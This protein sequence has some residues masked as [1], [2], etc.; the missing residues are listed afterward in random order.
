MRCSSLMD[1]STDWQSSPIGPTFERTRA[2]HH[3]GRRLPGVLFQQAAANARTDWRDLFEG[4]AE[5]LPETNRYAFQRR[6]L[7]QQGGGVLLGIRCRY[8]LAHQDSR[9]GYPLDPVSSYG[10]STPG[11][12]YCTHDEEMWAN[13][14]VET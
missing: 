13:A 1:G 10:R 9:T 12:G 6:L 11:K 7:I 14:L 2:M 4:H 8:R 5:F 3:D